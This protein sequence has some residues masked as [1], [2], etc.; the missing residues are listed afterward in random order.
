[1]NTKNQGRVISTVLAATL[2]IGAVSALCAGLLARPAPASEHASR[3]TLAPFA[4]ATLE[5]AFWACDYV[6][7]VYGPDSTPV[8]EC[9]AVTEELRK[10]R[11]GGDFNE[12]LGW[13]RQN[14]PAEHARIAADADPIAAS[15]ATR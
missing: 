10:K 8:N 4:G 11:F 1:M 5:G 7:T 6:A 12:M 2:T 9:S 3:L 14:K 13:W 15:V